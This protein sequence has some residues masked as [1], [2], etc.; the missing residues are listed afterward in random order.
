MK[1][2][3]KE[4][5]PTAL[6]AK[7]HPIHRWYNFV[8]GYSPEY[9]Q[10]TIQN[11]EKLNGYKPIKIYDPFAG[12]ATTNVVANVESIPSI[13]VE[14]NPIF[15]KL[16][17]A[18]VNANQVISEI[19][20][21]AQEF[22]N[23]IDNQEINI[24]I[25]QSLSID[26]STFLSKLFEEEALKQLLVLRD[27]V[28]TYKGEI[29]E[30]TGFIFLSKVIDMVTH[31]K[32]D[33]VYKAPTS[34]K[35]S[36]PV[37]EAILLAL[38]I[39]EEDRIFSESTTN[40]S[41]YVFD[42]S[43]DYKPASN[44]ID[45]VIFSPPYLNNFDF[46]EMTRMH[47]Y[48]WGEATSW[49]EISEKHRNHMIINTT[50]ALKVAKNADKQEEFRNYL[51]SSLIAK[52]DPLIEE[53]NLE[54]KLRPSKKNYHLLIYPYLGQMQQVLKNAYD[55]M[56]K[57]GRIHIVVSDA[58]FYGI[59]IDTQNFLVEIMMEIGYTDIQISRLRTRG[60]RWILE[61]RTKSDKQ[62]GEYEISGTKG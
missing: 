46:A 49:G 59:Y 57:N 45:L 53:L 20:H 8:A 29:K 19:S 61:K 14:R 35:N 62:L 56:R 41:E 6:T 51:P 18:K 36:R 10:L 11:F 47:M 38:S 54:R 58:A 9:V 23:A 4:K 17:K 43:V 28:A 22:L 52:L 21:I 26:A 5:M 25:P 55:S 16:G 48:F 31:S 1:M 60:D 44:S 34:L 42:S 39:F 2:I 37:K 15:F 27:I 50:T 32:T 40:V 12:C 13:G 7:T 3:S 33:G 24:D 30:I